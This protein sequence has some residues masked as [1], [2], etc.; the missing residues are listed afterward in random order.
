MRSQLPFIKNNCMIHRQSINGGGQSQITFILPANYRHLPIS[1]VGDFNQ[2]NPAAHPFH[3]CSNGSYRASI[4]LN[5]GQRYAF[6]YLSANGEWFNEGM[7]DAFEEN[8]FG[9]DNSVLVL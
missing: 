8:G 2:W 3:R 5:H 9:R 6:R 7:A 4:I 1:V